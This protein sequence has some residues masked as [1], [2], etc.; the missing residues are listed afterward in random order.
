MSAVEATEAR[1]QRGLAIAALC[2]ITHKK[3]EW[4]V[5][6]QTGRGHYRVHLG[7]DGS[8]APRCDCPD[9]EE[10]GEPCKHVFAVQFV[11]QREEKPDG[12][13]TVTET[14]TITG[15]TRAERRT[16][17]QDWPAYVKAQTTEK[18]HFQELLADLCRGIPEP[19]RTPGPGRKPIPLADQVFAV[20]FKVYSTV[21]ARRFTCDLQDAAERGHIAKAPHYTTIANT[22]ESPDVTPV[23]RDLIAESAR[24]L[25]SV[26]TDFAVDSS[27]F[28]TSRF[29]RW[30]DQKYGKPRTEYDWVKCHLMCGVRTNVVTSVEMTERD[31]A[32]APRFIPLVKATAERFRINEVSADKAYTGYENI[33][34]VADVGGSP[35]IPFRATASGCRGGLYEKLF[36]YYNLNRDDFLSHYHKRSNVESTFSMIKAKFGDSLRSKTDTAMINEALCKVL[37]HNIC[38][39]IQSIHELSVTAT[40]WEDEPAE[41]APTEADGPADA[42][43][44]IDQMI[45]MFAW[46]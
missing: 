18:R 7:P 24:P 32:D 30:F 20:A 2:K 11:R 46:M 27:G 28:S 1:R 42:T 22:L 43:S 6:S 34:A 33:Q 26:E 12:T 25:R 13:T 41:A 40:F 8:D 15:E 4:I 44:D 35:Y 23:L 31:T 29:V 45:G 10:R 17:R 3:D 16:Y 14:V 39:L 9:F 19:P 21:S 36:H 38:C 5:P 37:C